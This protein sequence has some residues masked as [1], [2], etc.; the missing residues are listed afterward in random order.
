MRLGVMGGLQLNRWAARVASAAVLSL[1]AWAPVAMAR[2]GVEV[3]PRSRFAYMVSA[4]DLETAAQRNYMQLAE[5]ARQQNAL[6]PD[7]HPLA[8]RLK[9]IAARLIP[10]TYEWNPRAQQWRWQVMA[11]NAKELNAF[12]MPGGKIAFFSGIVTELQLT[13]DEVAMVMGHEM[14]HALREHARAQTGKTRATSLGA[15]IISSILGLGNTG[16]AL[17]NVGSQLLTLKFSREDETEA[18]LVGMDLAA[19]AGYDPRAGISLWR[20][21]SAANKGAPPQWMSTHPASTTRIA[22][23]QAQLGKVLPVYERA[24]KPVQRFDAPRKTGAAYLDDAPALA[25]WGAAHK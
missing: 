25:Y 24:A 1:A 3:G 20:K 9:T 15:G 14:A 19:H 23:M 6:L 17:L 16:D 13:D 5:K 11:L 18:D 2:D 7:N 22:D 21:M 12:C 4:D 8:I 10:H